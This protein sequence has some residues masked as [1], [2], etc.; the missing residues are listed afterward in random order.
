LASSSEACGS[1]IWPKTAFGS[2][3]WVSDTGVLSAEFR[4]RVAEEARGAEPPVDHLGLVDR[5]SVVLGCGETGTDGNG[6]VDIGDGST[7]PADHVVV[8]VADTC[9]IAGDRAPRLNASQQT[10]PG[11]GGQHVIYGLMADL[12]KL[13]TNMVDDRVGVGVGIAVNGSEHLDPRAGD[14]QVMGAQQQI[15]HSEHLSLFL[16]SVKSSGSDQDL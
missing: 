11:E 6:A 4:N 13:L 5:V 9:L 2:C 16:E 12:G 15:L 1:S 10:G 7:G 14:P 3:S 8:V